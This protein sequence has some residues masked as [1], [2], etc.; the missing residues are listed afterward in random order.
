MRPARAGKGL[1]T[2]T[3]ENE[4]RATPDAIDAF[5]TS[6]VKLS[7]GC[8]TT[9]QMAPHL[10]EMAIVSDRWAQQTPG[11]AIGRRT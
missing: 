4:D 10:A 1:Q 9:A 5:T 8:E 2:L 3:T 7:A 11:V 6:L